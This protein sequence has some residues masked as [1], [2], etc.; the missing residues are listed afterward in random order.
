[1]DNS[2]PVKPDPTVI[3]LCGLL[4][5]RGPVESIK[6]WPR[7][8]GDITPPPCHLNQSKAAHAVT[9]AG[10]KCHRMTW[11]LWERRERPLTLDHVGAIVRAF[12]LDRDAVLAL[13]EWATGHRFEVAT[14]APTTTSDG[15]E[16]PAPA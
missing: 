8:N 7:A 2:R 9:L 15:A 5:L 1:M 12:D 13:I 6:V 3:R 11:S 4:A 16:L 10:Q 14:A